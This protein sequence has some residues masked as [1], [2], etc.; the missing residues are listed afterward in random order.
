M[1]KLIVNSVDLYVF[2]FKAYV[3]YHIVS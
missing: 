2:K 3:I 1:F